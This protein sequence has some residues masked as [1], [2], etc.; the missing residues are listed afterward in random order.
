MYGTSTLG[1]PAPHAVIFNRRDTGLRFGTGDTSSLFMYATPAA[2]IAS[3]A[4]QEC[5]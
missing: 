3:C 4:T 1:H 2:S 5:V